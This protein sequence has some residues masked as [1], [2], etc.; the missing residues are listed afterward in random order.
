MNNSRLN[1][2]EFLDVVAIPTYKEYSRVQDYITILENAI[3]SLSDMINTL[4]SDLDRTR[5]RVFEL[6]REKL[7]LQELVN[8]NT[9]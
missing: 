9:E 5:A 6:E 8:A 3:S 1:M 7:G 2:A 4:Q